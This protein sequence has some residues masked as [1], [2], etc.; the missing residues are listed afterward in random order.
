M[1]VRDSLLDSQLDKYLL[2]TYKSS[3]KCAALVEHWGS[4]R[5]FTE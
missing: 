5:F 3:M 1:A 4:T 2:K